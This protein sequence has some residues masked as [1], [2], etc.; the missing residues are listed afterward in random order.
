MKE[1]KKERKKEAKDVKK[2]ET[3]DMSEKKM[4]MKIR[5]R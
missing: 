3:I 2:N 5:K 4:K 1:R